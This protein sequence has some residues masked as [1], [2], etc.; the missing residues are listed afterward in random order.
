MDELT[1]KPTKIAFQC[2]VGFTLFTILLTYGMYFLKIDPNMDMGFGKK[3]FIFII[4]YLPFIA[5]I[6]YAQKYHRDEELKG[7]LSFGRGFSTGF[8]VALFSGLMIGLFMILYYQFLN[9]AAFEQILIQT[10]D[11]LS[12]NDS[13]DESAIEQA[14]SMTKKWFPF[15]IFIGSVL[16]CAIIGSIISLIGAAI[17]K[18]EGPVFAQVSE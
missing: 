4:S 3:T 10:E 11:K 2:A 7:F 8:R 14:L 15:M 12:E 17:Y 1:I 5:A 13:M 6:F 9:T 18:K 16:G